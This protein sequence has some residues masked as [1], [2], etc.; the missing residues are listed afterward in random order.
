MSETLDKPLV[1]WTNG[2]PGCSGLMG[3][4]TEHGAFRP[5]EDLTLEPFSYAW[6]KVA[7]ML[8]IESPTGVGF[9]YG[10]AGED[11][12]AGDMSTAKDNFTL[13]QSFFERFPGLQNNDL[14]LS[15]ESYSGH[16]IPTLAHL[17]VDAEG[18]DDTT[19]VGRRVAEQLRG[20]VVGNPYTD[21]IENA[22]GMFTAWFGHAMVPA[23]MYQKWFT[24]CGSHTDMRYYTDACW[25]ATMGGNETFDDEP[26]RVQCCELADAMWELVGD[27]DPYGLDYDVCNR[28][29]GVWVS[30]VLQQQPSQR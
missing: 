18:D 26:A 23:P 24:T 10:D 12:L 11:Y 21:P 22:H 27:I 17:I 14:Y 4:F 1:M 28:P 2:G 7:N 8:Y 9:S 3:L 13:L 29:E 30:T 6:N 20:V 16:Y 5:T 19:A 15:G 25:N